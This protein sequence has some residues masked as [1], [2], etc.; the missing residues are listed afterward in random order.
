MSFWLYIEA[1]NIYPLFFIPMSSSLILPI[2]KEVQ[3]EETDSENEGSDSENENVSLDETEIHTIQKDNFRITLYRTHIKDMIYRIEATDGDDKYNSGIDIDHFTGQECKECIRAC[4]ILL[5]K[6]FK[7]GSVNILVGGE[8]MICEFEGNIISAKI[9]LVRVVETQIELMMKKINRQDVENSKLRIRN[10]ELNN[11]VK[12]LVENMKKFSD[13]VDLLHGRISDVC[14][15]RFESK[16]NEEYSE[17]DGKI[18]VLTQCMKK[19]E[20]EKLATDQKKADDKSQVLTQCRTFS[21]RL[22]NAENEIANQKIELFELRSQIVNMRR[23]P[24]FPGAILGKWKCGNYS[25][26]LSKSDNGFVI[27]RC[28]LEDTVFIPSEMEWRAEKFYWK[29]SN[30]RVDSRYCYN[31]SI[32]DTV[33]ENNP[34]AENIFTRVSIPEIRLIDDLEYTR[35]VK[36][37]NFFIHERGPCTVQDWYPDRQ[38]GLVHAHGPHTIHT[39]LK[40]RFSFFLK[41]QPKYSFILVSGKADNND[42]RTLFQGERISFDS[43]SFK[44]SSKLGEET[45]N[46]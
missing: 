11:E 23:E 31:P 4:P 41:A 19:F 35:L 7:I 15:S 20:T 18:Q 28:H 38:W 25:M 40:D 8:N 43:N 24:L 21:N 3:F 14:E 45:W 37:Y 29:S 2:P 10:E 34:G 17:L 9:T 6:L 36:D 46:F 33:V 32:P 42:Y 1:K 5:E 13:S 39:Q 12:S 30:H 26:T 44:V 22:T 16:Y 27:R